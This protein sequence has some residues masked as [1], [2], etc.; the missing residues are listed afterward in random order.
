LSI[1]AQKNLIFSTTRLSQLIASSLFHAYRHPFRE[2]LNPQ[3]GSELTKR[4]LINTTPLPTLTDKEKQEI[5]NSLEILTPPSSNDVAEW[6]FYANRLWRR[7]QD[8]EALAAY[9]TTN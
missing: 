5:S 7:N 1:S 8:T 9:S 2:F 3:Q 4:L 6:L